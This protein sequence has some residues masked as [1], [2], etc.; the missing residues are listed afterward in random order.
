MT[1]QYRRLSNK[2]RLIEGMFHLNDLIGSLLKNI[3]MRRQIQVWVW[4]GVLVIEAICDALS[5]SSPVCFWFIIWY[6][7]A[8]LGFSKLLKTD[9]NSVHVRF[10]LITCE[11]PS[12]VS[13][14][15]LS[16]SFKL[17]TN[18]K[19]RKNSL[20]EIDTNPSPDNNHNSTVLVF[21]L[22]QTTCL[23]LT[24]DFPVGFCNQ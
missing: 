4:C 10:M 23:V 15:T 5:L 12:G 21:N 11:K 8:L 7:V 18:L 22:K 1:V 13:C 6:T 3:K 14:L 9:T 24:G 16:G 19:I 2:Q 20:L 17:T